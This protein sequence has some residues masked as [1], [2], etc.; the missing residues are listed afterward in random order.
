MRTLVQNITNH[1][2]EHPVRF[3]SSGIDTVLDTLFWKYAEENC[4]ESEETSKY[5]DLLYQELAQLSF[6]ES[7]EIIS[8]I[9]LLCAEHQ[10]L[11]FQVG[12]QVGFQL[13]NELNHEH[14]S[15]P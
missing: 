9:N 13:L 15:K 4:I 5:D 8:I 6:Q 3:D 11:S 14:A 2:A 10:R 12:V 7:D 1:L